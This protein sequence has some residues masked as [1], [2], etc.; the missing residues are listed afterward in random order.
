LKKHIFVD[1]RSKPMPDLAP[2]WVGHVCKFCG[3][4]SGLDG[5]QFRDMPKDMARCEKSPVRAGF[6]ESLSASVNCMEE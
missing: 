5:W 6:F 4:R 2:G 3:K 1:P